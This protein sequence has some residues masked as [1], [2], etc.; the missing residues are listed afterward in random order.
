A[1][2]KYNISRKNFG[3]EITESIFIHDIK[4][5]IRV[6][7]RFKDDEL[8]ISMDD[9]GTGYSS[10]NYLK[11][12]PID[13]LK[14]DKSFVD[15]LPDDKNDM[16]ITKAIISMAKT[17]GLKTLAEGVE[18]IDQLEFLQKEG[19]DYYQGYYFSKPILKNEFLTLTYAQFE[20]TDI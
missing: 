5:A 1:I 4:N 16:Q 2:K 20:L 8:L 6:L 14:I 10:L 9:F 7:N 15:G 3:I 13:I 18:T 19:C 12:L 11:Q 17:L